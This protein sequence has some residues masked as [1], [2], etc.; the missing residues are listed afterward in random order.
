[1][2]HGKKVPR[3]N[4]N[5]KTELLCTGCNSW[6]EHT[7]LNFMNKGH[8]KLNTICKCCTNRRN[9]EKY[10]NRPEYR[11]KLNKRSRE[12]HSRESTYKR[13]SSSEYR[14]K[15]NKKN[16]RKREEDPLFFKV[17]RLKSLWG[18]SRIQYEQMF[19]DQHNMCLICKTN[20]A[21][22]DFNSHVDH[23]HT[24]GEIRGILCGHCNRGIGCFLD[25]PAFLRSAALYLER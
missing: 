22:F 7:L 15:I 9:R 21:P 6:K 5:G 16:K 10:T 13:K 17:Q 3:R 11:S 24:S 4:Q 18:L 14:E 25:N 1:M 20:I 12:Y 2:V 19:T 8:G 23:C